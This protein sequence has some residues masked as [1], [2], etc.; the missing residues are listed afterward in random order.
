MKNFINK[1]L[2]YIN[3]TYIFIYPY[4][5]PV[6]ISYKNLVSNIIWFSINKYFKS[7]FKYFARLILKVF[8]DFIKIIYLP[9]SICFYFSK[10]RFIQINYSQIGSMGEQLKYM[11]EY[12]CLRNKKSLIFIPSTQTRSHINKIFINLNIIDSIILNFLALPLI[13]TNFISCDATISNALYDTSGDRMGKDHP[14]KIVQKFKKKF[15]NSLDLFKLN[16]HYVDEMEKH[17]ANKFKNF[18]IKKTIILHVRDESFLSTS[19]LRNASFENYFSTIKYLLDNGYFVIRLTHS[20]SKILKFTDSYKELNTDDSFNQFFQYYLISKCKGLMCCSSGPASL[21]AL[22]NAPILQIN[23][24]SYST[25]ATKKND[26]YLLKKVK[27]KDNELSS[28]I[29][30]FKMDFFYKY[31]VSL[32][33]MNQKGYVAIE[34]TEDEILE[35]TKEFIELNNNNFHNMNDDQK[36]FTQNIPKKSGFGYVESRISSYFQ[37]KYPELFKQKIN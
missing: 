2:L 11:V 35:A 30:L 33:R 4:M 32:A 36:S 15:G 13:H 16:Q 31:A 17:F 34:N 14:L 20:K 28:Y 27:N 12:N 5:A 1:V 22:L 8:L 23:I 19:Y 18:D 37:K 29:D 6:P 25:Y 3:T 7:S 24:F 10:Y 9:I 26:V 21:G